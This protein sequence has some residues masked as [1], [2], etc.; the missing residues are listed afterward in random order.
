MAEMPTGENMET[1][2]RKRFLTGREHL[3]VTFINSGLILGV[4]K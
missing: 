4:L 3:A 2:L 1:A